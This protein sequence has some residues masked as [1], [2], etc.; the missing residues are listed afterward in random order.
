MT[1]KPSRTTMCNLYSN[2]STQDEMRGLF[3]AADRLGNM[4]P[5]PAIF[6]DAEVAIVRAGREGRELVRA[7]WGW[8]KARFGWVT[9]VRNLDRWPWRD[10]IADVRHRCLVPATSFAEYHPAETDEKGRK[11]AVWFRLTSD[12]SDDPDARPPFAFAGL[13]R[14]WN[15]K[16]D[17]MRRKSDQPLA[18]DDV[19]TLATAFLTTEANEVVRPVHPKAMPVILEPDDYERWLHGDADDVRALQ[20]PLPDDGLET[21]FT[22]GRSDAA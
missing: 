1:H 19:R 11:A 8:S 17:G 20:K 21:A 2:R 12:G 6:P 16:E 5:Q 9:N 10:V 4:P 13:V 15:W 3:G 22:G 18:D 7:R 14:R